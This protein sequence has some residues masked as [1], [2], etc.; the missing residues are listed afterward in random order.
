MFGFLLLGLEDGGGGDFGLGVCVGGVQWGLG[1]GELDFEPA[2][3]GEGGLF[4]LLILGLGWEIGG[5]A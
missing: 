4:L 1:L 3:F 2:R 5:W